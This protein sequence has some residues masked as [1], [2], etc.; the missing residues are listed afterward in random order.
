[1]VIISRAWLRFHLAFAFLQLCQWHI[2]LSE[3]VLFCTEFMILFYAYDLGMCLGMPVN[4]VEVASFFKD[5]L[6]CLLIRCLFFHRSSESSFVNM[7]AGAADDVSSSL[8]I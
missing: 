5:C 7:T 2:L 6:M 1:M 4:V 3:E 8:F